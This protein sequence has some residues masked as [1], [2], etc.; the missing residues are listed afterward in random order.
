MGPF[1][2]EILQRRLTETNRKLFVFPGTGKKGHLHCVKG[3]WTKFRERIGLNDVTIHDL[4]RS[5]GAGMA[6][7]NVNIALVKQALHHNDIKTTINVY[8]RTRNEAVRDAKVAVH[9]QW[10]KDAELLNEKN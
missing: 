8:A 2:V 9:S 5:L 4:R 7:Q 10:F 6:N 3:A 1:E